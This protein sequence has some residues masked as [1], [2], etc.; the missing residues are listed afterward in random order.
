MK[1]RHFEELADILNGNGFDGGTVDDR[2]VNGGSS[3]LW[4]Q[5]DIVM[6]YEKQDSLQGMMED[7]LRIVK[8]V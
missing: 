1:K 2:S 6:S 4:K 5:H 8:V 7:K 3:R